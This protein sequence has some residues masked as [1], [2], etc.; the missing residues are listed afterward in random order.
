M[1]TLQPHSQY[2]RAARMF[3]LS[4][5]MGAIGGLGAVL[6]LQML[7]LAQT[8]LLGA[9][10]HVH[11][12]TIHQ[13][14]SRD[15]IPAASHW[16]WW[17]PVSTTLGGL[18]S[19]VLVYTFAPE[20]EGHG[21]DGAVKAYHQ[22]GGYIRPRVILIKSIASAVTIGSGG[23]AGREGPTA[24][25]AAG[26]GSLIGR[27]LHLSEDEKRLMVLTGMAAGLS[28]IFKS[29]LGTAIFAVEVLYSSMAF[30]GRALP[31]TLTS[32][33]IGFAVVCLFTGWGSLFT[34]PPS[35]GFD[36]PV[37]LVWYAILGI[38]SGLMAALL[39]TVFYRLRDGFRA[40]PLPNHIKPAIGGL[41]VGL[42]GM[43]APQILAGGYGVMQL[44][45]QG[46]VGVGVLFLLLLSVF[47]VL[48]LSLTI[49]SG[50]SGGV[51]APSLFVGALLG[52]AMATLLQ[53]LGVTD[54]PVAGLA[55]VGMAAVFGGAAR[56]PIATMV[57]VAEMTGGY[58]LMAPT[59][60]AVVIS[61]MLQVWLTRKARYPSLY[62]AQL[63]GPELSPVYKD[64]S[65]R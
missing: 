48:T 64:D 8:W 49:G 6:F 13:A 4:L 19:G 2:K 46:T 10:A 28:A 23:V 16:N 63:E 40:I 3:G 11:P 25:I 41:I 43:F 37:E 1:P 22:L 60:L 57:M 27:L 12:L 5:V 9:I 50:G 52:V 31:F 47:K 38:V 34:V 17:I 18:I 39:P 56:V 54:V 36:N 33:A 20:A 59:M 29:P 32:A 14:L 35:V 61:Y 55:L 44:A 24:Q 42:L 30:D 51:F 53:H 21:T 65:T 62:E 26:V 7:D 45:V 15:A 58:K